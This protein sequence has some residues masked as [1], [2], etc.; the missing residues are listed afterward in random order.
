MIFLISIY[1]VWESRWAKETCHHWRGFQRAIMVI[2]L[3]IWVLRKVRDG[4]SV[5]RKARLHGEKRWRANSYQLEQLSQ[6]VAVDFKGQNLP[7]QV[8][9]S[10]GFFR[11][12]LCVA[13]IKCEGW[14]WKKTTPPLLPALNLTSSTLTQSVWT[15]SRYSGDCCLNVTTKSLDACCICDS[16]WF[17]APSSSS[18]LL[19]LCKYLWKLWILLFH[20]FPKTGNCLSAMS[21]WSFRK[22]KKRH[23]GW[24]VTP[25][26]SSQLSQGS[27]MGNK[28]L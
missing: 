8:V 16:T 18:L 9:G 19:L 17:S 20:C 21:S 3:A 27:L 26:W 25:Q 14:S 24:C 13:D 1:C 15:L 10:L 4:L 2:L 23:G 5:I 7:R 12:F 6:S 11:F 22:R 28:S